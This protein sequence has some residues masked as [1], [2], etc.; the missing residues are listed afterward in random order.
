MAISQFDGATGPADC[1]RL[2]RTWQRSKNFSTKSLLKGLR[3]EE[4]FS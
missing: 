3:L 4:Q 2:I 1:L